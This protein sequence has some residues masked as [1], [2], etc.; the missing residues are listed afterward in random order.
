PGKCVDG[1]DFARDALEA[2]AGAILAQRMPEN[3]PTGSPVL[4]VPD[5]VRALGQIASH[6]RRRCNAKVIGVTGTAG[7]TTV[8]EI[9]A[10]LLSR[11]G[12]TAKNPLNLN[13]QIGLA[14][15][16]LDTN[17]AEEFW[18]MEVGISQS[19]DMD[20]LGEILRPDLA[21]ILNAG[22]GHAEGLGARKVPYYKAQLLKYIT[23]RGMGLVSAD[24]PELVRECRN[25]SSNLYFFS[26]DGKQV[27]YRAAY[28]G[29][30]AEG[31]GL[32][33][34]WLDGAP[35]DIEAP[36]RGRYGAEN[37]IAVAASA[38]L[39]GISRTAIAEGFV[40][41]CLPIQRFAHRAAGPWLVIDDSYNAN[42]L[43]C[44][45]MLEAAVET[46][47]GS[48]LVCVMGEMGELGEVAEAEHEQLGRVLAAAFPEAIFWKG[49]YREAVLNGLEREQYAGAF[50]PVDSPEEFCRAFERLDCSGGL[51]LFKGSRFNRLEEFVAA[52]ENRECGY[53]L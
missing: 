23:C 35:L 48:P 12:A 7:K 49:G 6:W 27:T 15:S 43:S 29:P 14:L 32:Y 53:A 10:Q 9:L 51:V 8:K 16:I 41:A 17:G 3:L 24:Y 20:E 2:G 42:P 1:H 22:T 13:N 18:V 36:F 28:S 4:L 34:L 46:A 44:R 21:V 45:R 33:R 40:D 5:T 30:A 39:L 47:Q 11:R 37:I 25:V 19:H 52:F 38:D 26:A 50:I 31:R